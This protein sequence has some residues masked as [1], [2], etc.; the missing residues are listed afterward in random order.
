MPNGIILFGGTDDSGEALEHC[1]EYA[2]DSSLAAFVWLWT[3][4]RPHFHVLCVPLTLIFVTF[5]NT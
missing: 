1:E 3:L 2:A 5:L 4:H